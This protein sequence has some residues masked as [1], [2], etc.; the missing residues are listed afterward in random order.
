MESGAYRHRARRRV[1]GASSHRLPSLERAGRADGRRGGGGCP[2]R[3]PRRDRGGWHRV[4]ARVPG[5][6][7]DAR[8][9]RGGCL[10][11][12]GL[13]AACS[14][15]HLG[16]RTRLR[17]RARGAG[18]GCHAA[19]L[20]PARTRHLRARRKLESARPGQPHQHPGVRR[21]VACALRDRPR[22]VGAALGSAE[23]PQAGGLE[24][25]RGGGG[26]RHHRSRARLHPVRPLDDLVPG[27]PGR[28]DAAD[29]RGAPRAHR[30][31][32]RLAC[33]GELGSRLLRVAC[34]A[35][36]R[37]S[38]P[39]AP[40]HGHHRRPARRPGPS[41]TRSD[42]EVRMPN[43]VIDLTVTV[44]SATKSPPSTDMP[45]EL[46]RHHRGPGFWQVT[47]VSQSLHTGS[48]IDAPL[49]CFADGGT[50]AEIPLE[51]V[52][53]EATVIDC[54]SAGPEEPVDV[55]TLEAGADDV[56]ESDILILHTGWTDR[57]WGRF[58]EF[59][60][61]SPYLTAEAAEWLVA[62]KPDAVAFDF[63]EEYC[64]R[65]PD[66]GSEDFICHRILLGAGIP[67][68]EQLTAVGSVGR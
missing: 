48:H 56:R 28:G 19:G 17:C 53:G 64:A 46:T 42:L 6:G 36:R 39:C 33:L 43:R 3:L 34:A 40:G 67:M 18:H 45:V 50:T 11:R 47:S 51:R 61:R 9:Y 59:F 22:C 55:A 21:P 30:P 65:L 10:L 35:R 5:A 13:C 44:D 31:Q 8:R 27:C 2:A 62:R 20:S 57:A 26:D 4:S 32:P 1:V 37:P 68:L 23:Y 24:T 49:H 54:T 63:F 14:R 12:G 25:R 66:F 58:P 7:V 41:R 16:R 38:R 15:L 60:T 52:I 29:T